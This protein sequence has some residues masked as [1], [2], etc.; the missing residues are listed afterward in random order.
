VSLWRQL[1]WRKPISSTVHQS[2]EKHRE[3]QTRPTLE[4]IHGDLCS[5]ISEYS[6]VFILA[7]ALDEYPEVQRDILLGNLSTLGPTV[8]LMLTSRHHID[9]TGSNGFSELNT[10]D[11]CAL[12]DDIRQYVHAQIAILPRLSGHI[13]KRPGLL[14]E[15]EA[16]VVS[17][18][19]GMCV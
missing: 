9:I 8:N 16:K 1:V 18:S 12:E 6:K 11:I 3:L 5:V 10:L 15:I 17:G 2:Y 7:D 13:Q 14:A 19:G 4:D